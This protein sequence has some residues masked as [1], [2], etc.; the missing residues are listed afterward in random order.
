MGVLYK[1]FQ[2]V[3][4]HL[5]VAH[6]FYNDQEFGVVYGAKCVFEVYVCQVYIFIG[7][8]C[9]FWGYSDHLNL[10]CCVSLWSEAFLDDV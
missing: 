1:C 6:V 8:S 2:L 3:L 10:S 9:I 7:E 5:W 4:P